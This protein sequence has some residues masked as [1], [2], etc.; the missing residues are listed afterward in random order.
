MLGLDEKI[1]YAG[2]YDYGKLYGKMRPG[3]TSCLTEEETEVSLLHAVRRWSARKKTS[4]KIGM[5]IYAL[6]KYEKVFRITAPIGGAGLV[7]VSTEPD[8]DVCSIAEKLQ[9]IIPKD[10]D[11]G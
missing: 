2:I 8:A 3:L 4:D 6:T 10:P 11:S 1:R 7:L 9:S 5:P